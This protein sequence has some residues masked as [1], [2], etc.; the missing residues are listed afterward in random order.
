MHTTIEI[1]SN[2]PDF[3]SGQRKEEGGEEA[4]HSSNNYMPKYVIQTVKNVEAQ[5]IEI[6]MIRSRLTVSIGE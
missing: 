6:S 5:K 3:G 4:Y 2:S 1:F